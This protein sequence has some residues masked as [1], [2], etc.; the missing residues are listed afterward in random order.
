MSW[1][2]VENSY[3]KS[4]VRVTKVIRQPD[5]HEIRELA[6]DI[7]LQGEFEKSY[8][9]GDNSQ[10]IPTDTMKNTVYA[11]ASQHPLNDIESFGKAVAEHFLQNFPHVAAV[12]LT[13]AQ[14]MWTRIETNGKSHQHSF[15]GGSQEKR[16][17]NID[18]TRGAV[19]VESGIE[20]L[21]VLKTTASEFTGYIK[22]KYTTLPE[23]KDRIF[24]T[25]VSAWWACGA[26]SVAYNTLHA[27]VR[28]VI[29]DVF[30]AHHSL[31][32]QQTLYEMCKAVL[33]ACPEIEVVR[34]EMPNQHRIPVDL[35]RLGLENKNEIFVPTNEP[36]GLISATVAREA[37][38][39]ERK[40]VVQ[41]ARQAQP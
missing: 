30:C 17:A 10:V 35:T 29:L 39:R 23:T 38:A 24:A 13:I 41:S 20:N 11:I 12:S 37:A 28:Q 8:L 22:D 34:M 5:R 2:L 18:A 27:K 21:V 32:V 40:E 4:R 36:Y 15:V 14:E 3:G 9:N 26:D 7:Q 6:V 25:A 33:D 31:A 19:D 1:S 16:V